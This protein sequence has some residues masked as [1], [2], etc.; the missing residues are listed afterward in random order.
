MAVER[1]EKDKQHK[2]ILSR[3]ITALQKF[4]SGI[5]KGRFSGFDF[6]GRFLTYN[7]I[8][9][10]SKLLQSSDLSDKEMDTNEEE[11]LLNGDAEKP[12]PS[13][14]WKSNSHSWLSFKSS[15]SPSEGSAGLPSA[16]R[17]HRGNI[18]GAGRSSGKRRTVQEETEVEAAFTTAST[19][20]RQINRILEL[21]MLQG[22]ISRRIKRRLAKNGRQ[23]QPSSHRKW[24]NECCWR[25]SS[26]RN[27]NNVDPYISSDSSDF[28]SK[29]KDIKGVLSRNSVG[30]TPVGRKSCNHYSVITHETI[31]NPNDQWL[32]YRS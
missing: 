14:R 30:R 17:R 7:P 8:L 16:W 2:I 26:Q 23:I 20:S 5:K 10:P 11:K 24:R 4:G 22:K 6:Q 19:R 13:L 25:N 27:C 31:Y 3:P 15:I 18:S 21:G 9:D 1:A 28:E 32:L 12:P 29:L